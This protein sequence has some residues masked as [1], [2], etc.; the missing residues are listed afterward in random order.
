MLK[1]AEKIDHNIKSTSWS[2]QE[3]ERLSAVIA[4]YKKKKQVKKKVKK[5]LSRKK[6]LG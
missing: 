2:V 4:D 1:N 3:T 5:Q 6:S